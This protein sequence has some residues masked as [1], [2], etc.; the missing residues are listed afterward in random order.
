[1]KKIAVLILPALLFSAIDLSAQVK[2]VA[3][4][5]SQA[6][7]AANGLADNAVNYQMIRSMR[8]FIL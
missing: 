5:N 2:P 1:M 3:K 6:N 4:S 8:G 7:S